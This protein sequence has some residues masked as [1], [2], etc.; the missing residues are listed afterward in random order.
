MITYIYLCDKEHLFSLYFPVAQK[1]AQNLAY[2][3]FVP[4]QICGVYMPITQF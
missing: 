2:N 4:I 1:L 3:T